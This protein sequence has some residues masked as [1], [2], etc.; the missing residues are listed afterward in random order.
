MMKYLCIIETLKGSSK[1]TKSLN[2]P[3]TKVEFTMIEGTPMEAAFGAAGY[4]N[5][6]QEEA[7]LSDLKLQICVA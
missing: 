2:S 5:P 6:S 4:S 7:V 3:L 1:T